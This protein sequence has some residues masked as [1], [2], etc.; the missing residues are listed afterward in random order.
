MCVC[1]Y[2]VSSRT[3]VK[4]VKITAN[5]TSLICRDLLFDTDDNSDDGDGICK[6]WTSLCCMTQCPL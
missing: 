3:Q 2:M 4:Q 6:V 5:D 1:A